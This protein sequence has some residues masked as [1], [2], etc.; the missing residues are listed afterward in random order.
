MED[1][2][3]SKLIQEGS[4]GCAFNPPIPCKKSKQK[5]KKSIVG[6]VM[7]KS[8][9]QVELQ[10]SAL[11]EGISGYKRFFI[12]QEKDE[13]SSKNFSAH[14][15]EYESVCEVYDKSPSKD[16]LQLFSSFG[17]RSLEKT[18]ITSQFDFIGTF[19][20]VLEGV[21]L[22]HKQGICHCDIHEGNILIDSRGTPRLIDFGAAFVGHAATEETIHKHS[23]PF[24]P[25]FDPQPPEMAVMNAIKDNIPIYT[26][27]QK[28]IEYKSVLTKASNILGLSILQQERNLQN[29]WRVED[30]SYTGDSFVPFFK[31]YWKAFDS[32][33]L[34]VLMLKILLKC[35]FLPSFIESTWRKSA[36]PITK[37]IHGLLKTNPLHRMSVEEAFQIISR[38]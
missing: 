28:V 1:T 38:I 30:R 9:A 8:D 35:F 29:F 23:F 6:K 27:I 26:A 24:T 17:G 11:I 5:R 33:S 19:R 25:S 31:T 13:C 37:V 36:I 2:Q 34:G 3:P 14:R 4:Y 21:S 16:L 18:Q 15:H 7:K 22:L 20:H 12:V 10:I 32:F